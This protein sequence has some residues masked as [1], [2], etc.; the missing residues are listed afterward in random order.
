MRIDSVQPEN[1]PAEGRYSKLCS[2]EGT[3]LKW[4][5]L[6]LSAVFLTAPSVAVAFQTALLP[7]VNLQPGPRSSRCA[8]NQPPQA[9]AGEDRTASAGDPVS[10]DASGSTDDGAIIAFEWN[11]GDGNFSGSPSPA[12]VY[13][14]PG[15]YLVTLTVTDNC[16]ASST[17]SLNVTVP[18]SVASTDPCTN[19]QVPTAEAGPNQQGS[20]GSPM[21]FD[22][23]GSSDP[24][25]TVIS[26][27]WN[28]GDGN[29]T[30]WQPNAV[31]SHTFAA[32]GTYY[33]RLWARDNCMVFS[34]A[35][36]L[37]VTVTSGNACAGNTPPYA[38]AGADRNASVGQ[39]IS[40]NGGA[41]FDA[42]GS[43][44]SYAW[45]FGNGQ[46]AAGVDVTHAY[47]TPG[48][49]TVTLTVTDNCGATASDA[50]V[51]TVTSSNPCS[52]NVPPTANAGPDR[53][54]AAGAPV[55][56][57][58]S[59]STDPNGNITEYWWNFGDGNYT[60]WQSQS[61]V[62]HT[63]AAA[64]NYTARLWVRDSCL[65]MSTV[66]LAVIT[67][68]QGG[69]NACAGNQ[70]PVANAGP[71]A[72]GTV[73]IAMSFSGSLSSDADGSIQSYSWNFGNGQ[74]A[75]GASVSHTYA[76][77][78]TYTV[79]LTVTDNCGAAASDTK[80]VVIAPQNPCANNGAPLA[81]AGSDQ[82]GTVGT[83]V[84]FNGSGS[85]DF[86]GTIVGY[87]WNFG[88]GATATGVSV[89]HSYAQVGTY[90]V[91]LTVTDSC[92][93]TG[94]DTAIVTIA[95][96]NPCLNNTAPTANAGPDR[97]V[98]AGNPVTFNGS[99]TDPNGQITAYWW[100]F[101]NGQATGW[102]SSPSATVTYTNAG[103]YTASLWVQDNC[104]AVS[105][106][107]TAV[108]TVA[109]ANPC[110]NNTPPT[111]NA[112]PDRSVQAGTA[113]SFSGSGSF[114]ANG[115][116]QSYA[117]NF[118]NGQTA[119]GLNVS[120]T[121]ANA[122]TYTVTLTVTDN[123]NAT[124]SDQAI[125]TV[126]PASG[127]TLTAHFKLYKLL[128]VNPITGS[129]NWVEL[130][131]SEQVERGAELRIDATTST[132]PIGFYSWQ[133]GNGGYN[134]G[135]VIYYTYDTP[136]S[137][138]IQLTVYDASWANSHTFS[139]TIAVV[140][141]MSFVGALP[142]ASD[143]SNDIAIDGNRAYTSHL[144][145]KLT[146]I[147]ISNPSNMTVLSTIEAPVGRAVAAANEAV[148]LC[149][150]AAGLAVYQGGGQ[151]VPT[152]LT[153][154]N[155]ALQD[156]Q[157][158]RDAVAAG[159]VV[160]LAA[161]IAGFKVLNMN[162]PSNPTVLG[163]RVL[164]NITSAEVIIVAEGKAYIADNAGKVHI[165]DVSAINVNNPSPATPVL[166]GTINN[167]WTVH[168]LT[169]TGTTLVAQ[170]PPDGLFF[171]NVANPASP[172]LLGNY[173]ISDDAVGQ[174]PS[175][176]LALG[177]RLYVTYGQVLG[178]GSAVAKVNMA[179]PSDAYIMEWI[180]LSNH[181]LSG[182]NRGPVLHNG[183]LFMANS[184]YKAAAINIPTGA[185]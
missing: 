128:S 154:Y 113:L 183:R 146:T 20:A 70:S 12:H 10:F 40:F 65:A 11:F 180:S 17:D 170:S 131:A 9:V 77:A 124:H 95:P 97:S 106:V 2:A 46:S 19:N 64:G 164:P 75:S 15:D 72:S 29:F 157:N 108:V 149:A 129:E 69:G 179:D 74:S 58:G 96:A 89:S 139:R 78:G 134:V 147:D 66:D 119:T 98:T 175:G 102:Q 41:S 36:Q 25:G 92:G 5:I 26:Y 181:N 137:Y 150:G 4:L 24:D 73:G 50:A 138:T 132:G 142:L 182:V 56:F 167:G 21:T 173:R 62:T 34:P 57:N 105:T 45:N 8:G 166:L 51:V 118:G 155:T 88:N 47:S 87:H 169:I 111:A 104:G 112:G 61:Q 48:S 82:S 67:V 116:I 55:N 86:T 16:G 33:V 120:H 136:G 39:S 52:N 18:T 38:D 84:N 163:V 90:T 121:Y 171:Y 30:G 178:I 145:G 28:F 76:N 6:G 159:K 80:V 122:G 14:Q 60:G 158:A 93:A 184:M 3:R 32:P 161:G 91:T 156:S 174:S 153:T 35:D 71:D 79:T 44:T 130:G 49:Y 151:A 27:W 115:T 114:D 23:T 42:G 160:Y 127:S 152:L 148:Y 53:Q 135:S 100:N 99:G 7:N 103:T 143:N 110:Q 54:V 117:W 101:G 168:H 63:Y 85:I 185:N 1:G 22:G 144:N 94:S 172:V 140:N 31:V 81:N 123:C 165:Y 126:T 176:V 68:G 83:A 37:T 107:D 43:I 162:N 125:V 177:N 109:P 133:M 59:G 13:E 141:T